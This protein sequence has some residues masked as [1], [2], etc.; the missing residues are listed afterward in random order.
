MDVQPLVAMCFTY[1][2]IWGGGGIEVA[3]LAFTSTLSN[4]AESDELMAQI[5]GAN[6]SRMSGLNC[7][8]T[9]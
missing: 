8:C 5:R 7:L 4:Y 6:V 2:I 9:V 1:D 3:V